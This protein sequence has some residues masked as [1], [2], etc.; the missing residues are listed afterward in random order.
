MTQVPAEDAAAVRYDWQRV[1]A[2]TVDE[3]SGRLH[4]LLDGRDGWSWADG[5]RWATSA[6]L[7][8]SPVLVG[9]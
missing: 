9:R 4:L 5:T 2:L 7:V 6:G 3:V 1:Q 8:P